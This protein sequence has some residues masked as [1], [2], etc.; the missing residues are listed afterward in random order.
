M[1]SALAR[2]LP[3]YHGFGYRIAQIENNTHC[4][5]KC[6]F[7]P[8]AYDTPAPKSVWNFLRSIKY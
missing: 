3:E 4:N 2:P 8:N 7:C 6:W 5:Y 1:S